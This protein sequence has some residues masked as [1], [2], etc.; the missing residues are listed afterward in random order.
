MILE[1][2]WNPQHYPA[3]SVADQFPCREIAV[4][5]LPFGSQLTVILRNLFPACREE[6]GQFGWIML[7]R[8]FVRFAP[9]TNSVGL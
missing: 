9:Q 1:H 7:S 2:L 6:T 8:Y 4:G 5:L 3:E